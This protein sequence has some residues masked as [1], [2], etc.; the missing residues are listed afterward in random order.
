MESEV[1]RRH[2]VAEILTVLTQGSA[3]FRDLK[4]R[5]GMP[6]TTLSKRVDELASSTLYMWVRFSV[7]YDGNSV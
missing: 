5:T 7:G 1:L 3:R 4:N 2:Y 6:S